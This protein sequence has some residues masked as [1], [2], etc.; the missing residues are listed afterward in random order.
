MRGRLFFVSG[1]S[2]SVRPGRN[3]PSTVMASPLWFESPPAASAFAGVRVILG[4]RHECH[5]PVC[6]PEWPASSPRRA[7]EE[8]PLHPAGRLL[9][10]RGATPTGTERLTVK[11]W[12]AGQPAA[13]AVAV[14]QGKH[15]GGRVL[16]KAAGVGRVARECAPVAQV[17]AV[18]SRASPAGQ[19]REL[20]SAAARACHRSGCRL[21]YSRPSKWMGSKGVEPERPP[22]AGRRPPLH[23]E[24]EGPNRV[25]K[26]PPC[27]AHDADAATAGAAGKA[28]AGLRAARAR[29]SSRRRRGSGAAAR[30]ASA[31][32]RVGSIAVP[33]RTTR[34]PSP[35]TDRPGLGTKAGG[36]YQR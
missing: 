16:D 17:P 19:V 24:D 32:K 9:L 12:D 10:H 22:R 6:R 29:A 11:A 5:A 20:A 23:A 34:P 28:R 3:H 26:G 13:A 33:L 4:E 21:S 7:G 27:R 36:E 15:A 14:E 2:W 25:G 1:N 8:R 18:G 31:S 35:R 30:R